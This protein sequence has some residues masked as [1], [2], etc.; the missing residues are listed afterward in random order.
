[1]EIY[2]CEN[3]TFL[4]VAAIFNDEKLKFVS[5]RLQKLARIILLKREL[6]SLEKH[7]S[8]S[9]QQIKTNKLFQTKAQRPRSKRMRNAEGGDAPQ[10]SK[11]S[12]VLSTAGRR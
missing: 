9:Q 5:N 4:K 10:L 1:M 2:H 11:Q 3:N 7:V 12:R 8:S 6:Y